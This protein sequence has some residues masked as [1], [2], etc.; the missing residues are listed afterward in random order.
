METKYSL[1]DDFNKGME[2]LTYHLSQT[3]YDS[4]MRE[5]IEAYKTEMLQW[6]EH[7]GIEQENGIRHATQGLWYSMYL[8]KKRLEN[9]GCKMQYKFGEYVRS[10]PYDT[11]QDTFVYKKDGKYIGEI[12][13]NIRSVWSCLHF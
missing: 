1:K 11:Q 4:Q 12:H 9:R 7:D 3:R 10:H 5:V 2:L 6:F 13:Y 8:E